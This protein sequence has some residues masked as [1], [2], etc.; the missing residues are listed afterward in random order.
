MHKLSLRS[1]LMYIFGGI[2]VLPIFILCIYMF[3]HTE[4]ILRDNTMKMT[5]LSLKQTDDNIRLSLDS[6]E[7]LLYQ[8]YT[9]DNVVA[10]MD[11]INSHEDVPVAT[12]QLRRYLRGLLNTKRYVR[13]ITIIANDGSVISY[14]QMAWSTYESS[15]M[16]EFSMDKEEIYDELSRYKQFE[17]C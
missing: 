15:W 8:V 17:F 10:W 2:S 14:D 7:D 13:A 3:Y 1:K 12:N 5:Q 16:G 4:G 9:D 11:A 6:Y